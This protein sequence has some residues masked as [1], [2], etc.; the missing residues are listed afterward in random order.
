MNSFDCKEIDFNKIIGLVHRSKFFKLKRGI[1]MNESLL[2]QINLDSINLPLKLKFTLK[3]QN[4]FNLEELLNTETKSLLRLRDVGDQTISKARK[5]I[6]DNLIRIRDSILSTRSIEN[7]DV[8]E[9]DAL[10]V[11]KYFPLLKGTFVTNR[12]YYNSVN[13]NCSC[14]RLPKS[15]SEYIKN[16]KNLNLICNLLNTE[17]DDL[18]KEPN[19][20]H[21][22]VGKLQTQIIDYLNLK[23]VIFI[24]V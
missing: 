12:V 20:G 15:I 19:I 22:T 6:I 10:F 21:K 14:I 18:I 8:F 23:R 7:P 1:K 24:D 13:Q 16:N 17:Y 5:I 4:V 3:K 2:R 11:G 9:D